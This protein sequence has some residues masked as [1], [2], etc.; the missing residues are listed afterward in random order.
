MVFLENHIN[1][2]SQIDF[3]KTLELFKMFENEIFY[4]ARLKD[5]KKEKTRKSLEILVNPKNVFYK[6]SRLACLTT[7]MNDPQ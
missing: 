3:F 6:N 1:Q 5:M 4:T 2:D 7:H